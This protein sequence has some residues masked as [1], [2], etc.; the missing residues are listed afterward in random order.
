MV[1]RFK[2]HTHRP[3]RLFT[4]S[5]SRMTRHIG[6][7]SLTLLH[8]CKSLPAPIRRCHKPLVNPD[9]R[10]RQL[11][12]HRQ[13]IHRR[14]RCLCT[15]IKPAARSAPIRVASQL[16]RPGPPPWARGYV[17]GL[18]YI[19]FVKNFE[20]ITNR[21][22]LSSKVAVGFAAMTSSRDFP[23]DFS[24]TILSRTVTSISRN[25]IS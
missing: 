6:R 22:H 24:A 2:S 21:P 8:A 7:R 19:S 18:S 3:V 16:L 14:P 13:L 20:S 5:L 4:W 12:D 25:S 10:A 17:Y 11:G 9:A 23:S 1:S 15:E